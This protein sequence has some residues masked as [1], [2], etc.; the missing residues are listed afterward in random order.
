MLVNV[1][2]GRVL[3]LIPPLIIDS[4]QAEM[5]VDAVCAGIE[6]LESE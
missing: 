3:R 2:Q 5:I 6:C 4:E 1:T